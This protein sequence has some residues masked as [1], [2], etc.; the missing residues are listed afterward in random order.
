VNLDERLWRYHDR[1]HC[2][3]YAMC[4]ACAAVWHWETFMEIP[5]YSARPNLE[6]GRKVG[7]H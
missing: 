5:E 3:A 2:G 7:G 6:T 1:F 4:D